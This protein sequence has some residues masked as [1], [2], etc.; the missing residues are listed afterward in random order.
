M[1]PGKIEFQMTDVA[2]LDRHD[3]ILLF[4]VMIAEETRRAPEIAELSPQQEN[5]KLFEALRLTQ[6]ALAEERGRRL[7]AEAALAWYIVKRVRFPR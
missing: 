7:K 6:R 2:T 3:R 4:S 1:R 5:Q